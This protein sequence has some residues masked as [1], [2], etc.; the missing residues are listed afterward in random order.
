MVET[1]KVTLSCSNTVDGPIYVI[2]RVGTLQNKDAL[3]D[4]D[5][6][7]HRWGAEPHVEACRNEFPESM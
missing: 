4:A 5:E 3:S 2:V 7:M 6:P 1:M